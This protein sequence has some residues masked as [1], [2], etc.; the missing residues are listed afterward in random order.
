MAIVATGV[1]A[2]GDS[3]SMGNAATLV[4]GQRIHVCAQPN[5]LAATGVIPT[6]PCH[7]TRHT[8]AAFV[9]DAEL[10]QVLAYA[11]S[12]RLFLEPEFRVL[13][14]C[15]TQGQKVVGHFIQHGIL[16]L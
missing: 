11:A 4:N 13:V 16:G 14:Q 9:S 5:T 7:D 6:Y 1:H 2:T 12:G 8:D 3:R 15:M 10:V